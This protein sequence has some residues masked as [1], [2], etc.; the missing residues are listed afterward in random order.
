VAT[1][2]NESYA[3]TAA[4][5][6][7]GD[8]MVPPFTVTINSVQHDVTTVYLNPCFSFDDDGPNSMDLA[9]IKLDTTS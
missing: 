5:C 8:G 4:H 7:V 1:L 9:L 6:I 2:I 3:I